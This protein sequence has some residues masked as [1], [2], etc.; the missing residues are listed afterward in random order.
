[1]DEPPGTSG[2]KGG[3]KREV[4]EE[5]KCFVMSTSRLLI[6]DEEA[7]PVTMTPIAKG[8]NLFPTSLPRHDNLYKKKEKK[9]QHR[10]LK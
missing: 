9:K 6:Q 1:M 4:E 10:C 3:E 2:T 8:Q 5:L 7:G